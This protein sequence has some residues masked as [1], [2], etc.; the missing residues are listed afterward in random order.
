MQGQ[1][2]LGL[3]FFYYY[4]PINTFILKIF[5]YLCSGIGF[6]MWNEKGIRCKS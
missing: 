4:F 5:A 1:F 2:R 3:P 6:Q